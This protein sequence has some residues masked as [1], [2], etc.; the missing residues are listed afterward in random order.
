MSEDIKNIYDRHIKLINDHKRKQRIEHI[1]RD[2]RIWKIILSKNSSNCFHFL[3]K[4]L[5]F[6]MDIILKTLKID[7]EQ[8]IERISNYLI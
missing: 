2:I 4:N 6:A 1:K 3:L 8:I 7:E 5:L